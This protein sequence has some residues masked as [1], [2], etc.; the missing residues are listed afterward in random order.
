ISFDPRKNKIS[1][2]RNTETC[3]SKPESKIPVFVIPT[4][5]ELVMTEDAFALMKGTYDTHTH[6]KYSFQNRDYVNKGRAE[7]LVHELKKNPDL[8]EIIAKPK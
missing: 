2:T 8:A 1:C 6:F 7:G 5:E 3:I 4:D